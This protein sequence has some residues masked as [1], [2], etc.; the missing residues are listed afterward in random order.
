MCSKHFII[1]IRF[2]VQYVLLYIIHMLLE[3]YRVQQ[4]FYS[5]IFDLLF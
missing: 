4:L 2:L 3:N 1:V 5:K